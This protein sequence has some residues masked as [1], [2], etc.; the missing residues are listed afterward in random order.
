LTKLVGSIFYLAPE[1]IKSKYNEKCDVWSCGVILYVLLCGSPPFYSSKEPEVMRKILN[2][3]LEFKG[4][5]CSISGSIWGKR[6][7]E[8]K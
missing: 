1:V 2:D 7:A 8:V 4:K 5:R 3:S 6:S